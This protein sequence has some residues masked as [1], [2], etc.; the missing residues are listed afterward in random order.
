MY[1]FD[2][3]PQM[4][5]QQCVWPTCRRTPG[6]RICRT[7]SGP[8]GTSAASS[9]PRTKTLASQRDSPSS[10]SRWEWREGWSFLRVPLHSVFM[11]YI[12]ICWGYFFWERCH[13]DCIFN[14][15]KVFGIFCCINYSLF[16][17]IGQNQ[18]S[19]CG[20]SVLTCCPFRLLQHVFLTY[21]YSYWVNNAFKCYSWLIITD[22]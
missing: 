2:C 16:Q 10:I 4:R 13:T 14:S 3:C 15:W 6:N 11:R 18:C 20:N 7:S 8:S 17:Q 1:C 12:H 19:L 21:F 22:K 5:Q 9:W